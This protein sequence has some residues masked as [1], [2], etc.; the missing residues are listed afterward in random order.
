MIIWYFALHPEN[1]VIVRDM[2]SDDREKYVYCALYI[3]TM[4]PSR[5]NTK[6]KPSLNYNLH[7]ITR[8]VKPNIVE[9]TENT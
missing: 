9:S 5:N 1:F 2:L 3:I 4:R 8:Y 7:C 6:F